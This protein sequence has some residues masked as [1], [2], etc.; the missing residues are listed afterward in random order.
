[1]GS[2]YRV[3]SL[4]FRALGFEFMVLGLGQYPK[5]NL[6]GLEFRIPA[7]RAY[8]RDYDLIKSK[9]HTAAT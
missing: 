6:W 4:W 2:G 5:C 1:M 7:T 8:D 3:L 9:P